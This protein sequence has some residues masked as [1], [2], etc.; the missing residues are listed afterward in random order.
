MWNVFDIGTS[1]HRVRKIS[2]QSPYSITSTKDA[3]YWSDG[4][5]SAIWKL[6]KTDTSQMKMVFHTN[7]GRP[8]GIS[9][10]RNTKPDCNS[11]TTSQTLKPFNMVTQSVTKEDACTGF[12]I[13]GNC[14]LTSINVPVCHCDFGF[15]GK[16]CQRHLCQGFC[17]NGGKC[18]VDE[19][20]REPK[21]RCADGFFGVNCNVTR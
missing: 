18:F 20:T 6:S 11:E 4:H 19:F 13:H 1:V 17:A 12:C 9:T 5:N 14:S 21:C 2:D 15:G 16:K 7:G 8:M 10:L 3:I